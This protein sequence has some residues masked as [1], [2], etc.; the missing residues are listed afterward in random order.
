MFKQAFYF[1]TMRKYVAL[2]GTL[3]NE[4]YISRT[5]NDNR[6]QAFIRVPITYAPKEK[7]LARVIG[8]PGID[9]ETATVPLP[10]MSF[11]MTSVMY[12]PSR[13]LRSTGRSVVKDTDNPS[14]LKYQYNPVPYNFG[15]RLHVYVKNAEDGTKIVEQILP[16]FTPDFTV[17][18][19]IIPEMDIHMDIPVILNTIEQSDSYDGDFTQRQAIV[20]TI[21]FTLKGYI[22]GPVKKSAIILF[23]NTAT[24]VPSGIDDIND[25]VGN[26][27]FYNYTVIQP[28]LTANGDPTT[29]ANNSISPFLI[30]E[31]DDWG[32]VIN[33]TYGA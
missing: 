30:N 15:F 26:T 3:F 31:D 17:S 12:D 23:A 20:W 2:F 22:Y 24:Y 5:G 14:K 9:R 21:D 33:T 13:K 11:E 19:N 7:M 1:Q 10:L 6:T 4:I 25:A 16:F 8:D 32:F 28:G 27:Q 18:A 29:D